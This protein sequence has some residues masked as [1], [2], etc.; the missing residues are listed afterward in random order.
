MTAF[1][2]TTCYGGIRRETGVDLPGAGAD[3]REAA[4]ATGEWFKEVSGEFQPAS[5]GSWK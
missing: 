1:F 5:N 3:L 2:F 4:V